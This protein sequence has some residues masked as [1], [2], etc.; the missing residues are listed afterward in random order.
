MLTIDL[1]KETNP[2][3][4][5]DDVGIFVSNALREKSISLFSAFLLNQDVLRLRRIGY[6]QPAWSHQF[7]ISSLLA[8]YMQYLCGLAIGE[9]GISRSVASWLREDFPLLG[10]KR[11][12][13]VKQHLADLSN[14]EPTVERLEELA[15][16]RSGY[17]ALRDDAGPYHTEV[18]PYDYYSPEDVL[19]GRSTDEV[20]KS[21][22]EPVVEELM[23][24]I[25]AWHGGS[26]NGL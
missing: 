8:L 22:I 11:E 13:F 24:A 4:V 26:D 7:S 25:S 21:G 6:R 18:F 2:L 17:D 12:H 5:A 14:F 19:L 23:L 16:I 15:A 3:I 9:D 20:E 10:D 1:G